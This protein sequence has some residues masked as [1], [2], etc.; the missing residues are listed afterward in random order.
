MLPETVAGLA[1]GTNGGVGQVAATEKQPMM[2]QCFLFM[3]W[4]DQSKFSLL[5]ILQYFNCVADNVV[6]GSL[7]PPEPQSSGP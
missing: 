5:N 7:T 3:H 2:H 4:C 1:N 6:S